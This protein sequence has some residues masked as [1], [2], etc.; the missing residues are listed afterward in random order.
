ML[1]LTEVGLAKQ[2]QR[3][4]DSIDHGRFKVNGTIVDNVALYKKERVGDTIRIYLA[5][6]LEHSGTISE[7]TLVDTDGDAVAISD[8]VILKPNNKGIYVTFKYKYFEEEVT[9]VE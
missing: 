4:L 9:A 2:A 6:G 1:T 8:E 7:I 5:L 3:F